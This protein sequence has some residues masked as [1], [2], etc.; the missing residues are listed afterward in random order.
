M[1]VTNFDSVTLDSNLVV[2]GTQTLTGATTI[3]GATT[4]GGALAVTGAVTNASTV[5]N[6]G[7]VTNTVGDATGLLVAQRYGGVATEGLELLVLDET[8][9]LSATASA[10]DLAIDIP[11]GA[12]I[13]SVQGEVASVASA[14][15]AISIGFGIAG[16]TNLY[17]SCAIASNSKNNTIADWAVLASAEDI[18]LFSVS[19]SG[20]SVGTLDAGSVRV[21][22]VYWALNSLVDG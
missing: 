3:A 5:A 13:V 14:T 22:I 20:D 19:S 4:I 2:T 10:F 7:A 6:Q 18:Q 11:S 17:G 16:N 15:T 12:V 8:V 1:A 21:R 9:S